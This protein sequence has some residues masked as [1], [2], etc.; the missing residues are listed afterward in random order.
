MLKGNMRH[1]FLKKQKS[2]KTERKLAEIFK[3]NHIKFKAR[4]I[5]QGYEVDFLIGRVIIEIDGS[6]HKHIDRKRE[7]LLLDAGYIPLHISVKEIYESDGKDIIHLIKTN[8]YDTKNR[9]K[10]FVRVD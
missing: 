9:H 8:N 2:T 7:Q 1:A 4:W 6:V 10:N 5:V 3:R